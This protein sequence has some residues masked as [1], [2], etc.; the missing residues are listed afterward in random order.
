MGR[1]YGPGKKSESRER[2][3]LDAT[4]ALAGAAQP[5]GPGRR[6]LDA[7]AGV[8]C[9][10]VCEEDRLHGIFT[11]RDLMHRVL[12]KGKPLTLPVAECMTPGPVIVHPKDS[13][14][15]PSGAW[16]KAAIAICPSSATTAGRSGCF[17]QTD[18]PLLGEHFRRPFTI[19]PRPRGG[20][21]GARRSLRGAESR[22]RRAESQKIAESREPDCGG[23]R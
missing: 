3:S 6:R 18:R 7:R 2:L 16:R 4:A 14:P 17:G 8:G 19:C 15:P 23:P 22:E 13:M 1:V 11:E 10:L 5:N 21:P 9:I 20:S 12:G